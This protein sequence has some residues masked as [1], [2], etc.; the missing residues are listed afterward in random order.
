MSSSEVFNK[1]RSLNGKSKS[2]NVTSL[3]VN[4][5]LITLKEDIVEEFSNSFFKISSSENYKQSFL[6]YKRSIE[7]NDICIPLNQTDVYNIPFSL[8]ELQ[9]ALS[10]CKGSSA[11]PDMIHYDMIKNI[12]SSDFVYLLDFYNKLFSTGTFPMNWRK[13]ILIPILKKGKNPIHIN[14]YRPISLTNCLCKILERMINK[15][16]QWFLES[17]NKINTFQSGF[18]K[19]RSTIDNLLYL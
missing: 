15:R 11:G 2:T 5:Q 10:D 7:S 13:A 18:R 6:V 14:N 16:L 19:H 8:I 12:N 17:N 3:L 1:I 4:D 9:N